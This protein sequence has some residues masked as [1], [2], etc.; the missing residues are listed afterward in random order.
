MKRQSLLLFTL[1]LSAAIVYGQQEYNPYQSIGKKA[2]VL[3]ASH[4]KYVEVFDYDSIQ[5]IGSVMINIHTRKIVKLLNAQT[6]FKKYSDNS[7]SSRWFSPDPL[8]QKYFQWSPYVFGANNPI[9]YN[10]PD[11]REV[12]D[13]KTGKH[14]DVTFN[15]DGSLKSIGK[16]ANADFVQMANG[17]AK[18]AEGL[19]ELHNMVS[20]KTKISMTI[21][22]DNIA[23]S[24]DGNVKGGVTDP[25]IGQ[26]TINGKL[27]GEKYLSSAKITI[28]EKG[29][30][31]IADDNNG[32]M[33]IG[34]QLVD[35]KDIS[36]ENI[37]YSFG[38]HEAT[39][40][41]DKNSSSDLAPKGTNTEKN[42]Y[43][44]QLLYIQQLEQQT[45]PPSPTQDT[46]PPQQP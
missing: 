21:D 26:A 25:V 16:N 15:K 40:A 6:T 13:P 19:K 33:M 37:M 22:R 30:Q 27:V 32:R 14:I 3:T 38:V 43:A 23:Y 20:S 34:G 11:G 44:N 7:S 28:Y 9:R 42:P 2:K 10:D 18:T 4:G 5:R 39:H 12:V 46:T 1:I 41:T 45:K 29:I 35:T 24:K 31:K 8:A 17:M 36:L